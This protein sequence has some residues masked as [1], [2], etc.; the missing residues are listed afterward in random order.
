MIQIMPLFVHVFE[1]CGNFHIILYNRTF[2]I[3]NVLFLYYEDISIPYY[4]TKKL[5]LF[6]FYFQ[7]IFSKMKK[8]FDFLIIYCYSKGRKLLEIKKEGDFEMPKAKKGT[9]KQVA[10]T[11]VN[12]VT[13]GVIIQEE[14]PATDSVETE[15]TAESTVEGTEEAAGTIEEP[16]EENADN[17]EET[18]EKK[19]EAAEEPGTVVEEEQAKKRGRKPKAV[20]EEAEKV[21]KKRG[22]KPKAAAE[23]TVKEE[24]AATPKKRGR[25]PKAEKAA[26]EA[27]VV[28]D[29]LPAPVEGPKKRGRKPKAETV[30]NAVAADI[31]PA[32]AEGPK[33][34]GR[35]PKAVTEQQAAAEVKVPK[36]RGRKPKGYYAANAIASSEPD[37][38]PKKRGRKPLADNSGARVNISI[39]SASGGQIDLEEIRKRIDKIE[40]SY[41]AI[42][43]YIKPEDN[44]A[45]YV[46][47]K[48]LGSIDLW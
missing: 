18:S 14:V 31:V 6:N 37:V 21:P 42:D 4:R 44:K 41:E 45:F 28:T 23:E 7:I 24:P 39:Q 34:R 33:K 40:G 47:D 22:R 20:K 5:G 1:W 46:I 15:E 16:K 29:V 3:W 12:E 26:N 10:E 8:T 35:K 2:L 17:M 25:K 32:P 11:V 38:L 48:K 9:E 19:D 30:A 36:K 27:A 13:E 43:I